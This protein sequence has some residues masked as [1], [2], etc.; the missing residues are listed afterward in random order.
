[1][2][3]LTFILPIRVD[4]MIRLENLLAVIDFLKSTSAQI[5]II[6]AS[7]CYGYEIRKMLP[8]GKELNFTHIEDDDP[9]FFRTHFINVALKEVDTDVVSVWDADVLVD[10]KQLSSSYE[11]ILSG[12]YEASFPYDGLF[13][14]TDESFRKE[15]LK[16]HDMRMLLKYKNYFNYLYGE[17]FVGGGF[18]INTEKYKAAG[19]ENENFYGWGPEDLDRVQH[20]EAHGYRIHRSDG[21]MFHLNHPRDI[22]GGPRTKLYQDLCFNQLNKSLYM[23]LRDDVLYTG[24]NDRFE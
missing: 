9:V 10:K 7:T 13:L 24:N 19:G 16:Q 18:L 15:Y 3:R 17:N 6:E 22:N 23:S 1:M 14:N 21:P 2:K 11:A 8:R 20:W 5:L 12:D 4:S